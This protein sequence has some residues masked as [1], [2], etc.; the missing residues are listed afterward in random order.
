MTGLSPDFADENVGFFT[1]PY[2]M[3]AKLGKPVIDRANKAVHITLPSGL[4]RTADCRNQ[5]TFKG[6]F[7][8]V[9]FS[10]S[11]KAKSSDIGR[12]AALDRAQF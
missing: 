9:R 5:A 6:R 11:F 2:E 4:T 10:A 1:A 12:L 7:R 3:R 8:G